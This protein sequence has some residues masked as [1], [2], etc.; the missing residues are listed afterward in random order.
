LRNITQLYNAY[1]IQ[2]DVFVKAVKLSKPSKLINPV[3]NYR[4]KH[5]TPATDDLGQRLDRYMR[6]IFPG[7]KLG[8]IYEAM[9]TK[10]IT[11]AGKK[12]PES[13]RLRAWDEINI[14]ISEEQ[15]LNWTKIDNKKDIENR[16]LKI[17]DWRLKIERILY[18][19]DD[20]LVYDKPSGLIVHSPDHKTDEVS[21]IEQIEDYLIADGWKPSGT[22]AHPALAHR[23]D[24]DTSGVIISC[25][26]RLSYEHMAE[27]FRTRKVEKTYLALVAGIPEP[28]EGVINAPLLRQ[29]TGRTDEAKVTV[30]P[31]GQTAETSYKTLFSSDN[32]KCKRQSAKWNTCNNWDGTAVEWW[33]FMKNS[34]ILNFE[35]WILP[36][37]L[38]ELHPKTG[39]THQIRVH[40]A[41]IGHPL[42]G[43]RRYGWPSVTRFTELAHLHTRR[44]HLLHAQKVEF[45]HPK[46][47]KKIEIESS[48]NF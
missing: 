31:S 32:A 34:P 48:I 45:I 42:I 46:T 19:D 4:M 22:F 43:D 10:K 35:F 29:D 33:E 2:K 28:R 9:R 13:T 39:R 23:I 25:L 47:G 8:E 6:K 12:L 21:L 7:A 26:N 15:Y 30:D 37:S 1:D 40:M 41:H 17:E 5:I 18:R 44:G 11:L 16:Q 24:R 14:D 36:W 20:I 27:Q 38:I 3:N